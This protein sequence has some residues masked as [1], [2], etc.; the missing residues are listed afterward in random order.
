MLPVACSM[1][2]SAACHHCHALHSALTRH[3]C[4]LVAFH[5]Y[6]T[7]ENAPTHAPTFACTLLAATFG[8]VTEIVLSLA[9]LN[10]GLFDVVADS[11]LGSILSN[12][13][14]VL[15][16]PR[17]YCFHAHYMPLSGSLYT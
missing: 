9:A 3:S 15:G 14:L 2:G 5:P 13:L 12:M 10:R 17:Q 16:E 1:V 8:N 6:G 11:L 7:S 4:V